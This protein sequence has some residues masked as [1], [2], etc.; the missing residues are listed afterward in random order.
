MRPWPCLPVPASCCGNVAGTVAVGSSDWLLACQASI[1]QKEAVTVPGRNALTH[2]VT[3]PHS[4]CDRARIIPALASMAFRLRLSHAL[5]SNVTGPESFQLWLAWHS[6]SGSVIWSL[7]KTP[8][9][10]Y[11]RLY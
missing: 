1:T 9:F 3:E 6:G 8:E 2:T 5:T 4:H 7:G 10:R 11:Q